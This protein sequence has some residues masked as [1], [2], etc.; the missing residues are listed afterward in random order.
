MGA[1]LLKYRFLILCLIL[2]VLMVF[3]AI[4]GQWGGDFWEHAAV[5]Q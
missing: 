3:Q 1:Y 5:V 2:F 4:S